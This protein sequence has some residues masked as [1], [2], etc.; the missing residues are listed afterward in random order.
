MDNE[1]A[2]IRQ[3]L[4][5]IITHIDRIEQARKKVIDKRI[6]SFRDIPLHR[7]NVSVRSHN[8]VQSPQ[9]F[10]RNGKWFDK[11]ACY[12]IGDLFDALSIHN[13][14]P[15]S[16]PDPNKYVSLFARRFTAIHKCGRHAAIEI[17]DSISKLY[18]SHRSQ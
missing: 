8:I 6:D 9:R 3:R 17:A 12:T 13:N 2:V 5:E 16:H 10:Y 4:N 15:E 1:L 11:A 7:L 18:R 14:E